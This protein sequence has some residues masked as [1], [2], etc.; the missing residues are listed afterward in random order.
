MKHTVVILLSLLLPVTALAEE[1][2][3]DDAA[4][5]VATAPPPQPPPSARRIKFH[6]V[7]GYTSSGLLLA[8]GVVGMAQLGSMRG[9]GHDYRDAQGEDDLGVGC[10]GYIQDLWAEPKHATLRG[11]HGGLIVA[12]EV[13][14]ITNAVSGMRMR[15]QGFKPGKLHRAAMITNASLLLAEVGLGVGTTVAMSKGNHDALV[16]LG[17]AHA[18]LGLVIP[19][20]QLGSGVAIDHATR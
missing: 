8:G 10:Q 18:V 11:I 9:E 16:P 12:G 3:T 19:I 5:A 17:G 6:R 7:A 15:T 14:N 2:A 4:T 13:L 1:P 20:F